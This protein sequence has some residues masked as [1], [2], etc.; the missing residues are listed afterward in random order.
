MLG[1]AAIAVAGCDRLG[2][3][4]HSAKSSPPAAPEPAV[5]PDVRALAGVS[6][7]DFAARAD[8]ERYRLEALGL[9]AADAA[10]FQSVMAPAAEAE[11]VSG[12]GADALVFA[13]CPP[14]GC[15]QGMAVFAID[16]ATGAA[17]VGVRDQEGTDVLA[18]NARVEALLGLTSLSGRWDDPRREIRIV[19]D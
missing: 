2:L 11:L 8:L 4:P 14:E 19:E 17:F 1:V 9:T 15:D 3:G 12:G 10:R 6:Y 5:A 16:A 7:A 18:P 13:G